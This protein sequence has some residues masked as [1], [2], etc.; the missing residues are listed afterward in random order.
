MQEHYEQEIARLEYEKSLE[1][2]KASTHLTNLNVNTSS[3]SAYD[4]SVL[5]K[6]YVDEIDRLSLIIQELE[7][8]IQTFKLKIAEMERN[9]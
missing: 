5:L 8:E 3:A 9:R 1:K 6:P 4:Q 2:T 7:D